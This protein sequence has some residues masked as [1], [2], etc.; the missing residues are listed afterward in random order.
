M[1]ELVLTQDSVSGSDDDGSHD[2]RFVQNVSPASCYGGGIEYWTIADCRLGHHSLISGCQADLCHWFRFRLPL[3]QNDNIDITEARLTLFWNPNIDLDIGN[4]ARTANVGISTGEE[5][6]IKIG[7]Y[8][9]DDAPY[10]TSAS[11]AKSKLAT[12]TDQIEWSDA[13]ID[14]FDAQYVDSVVSASFCE[15]DI[16]TL[17]EAATIYRPGW[18]SNNHILIFL[19]PVINPGIESRYVAFRTWSWLKWQI[20][21]GELNAVEMITA[22]TLYLEYTVNTP[23][24]DLGDKHVE[25]ELDI[26]QS[27]NVF[28]PQVPP[29]EHELTIEQTITTEMIYGREIEHELEIEQFLDYG[30]I[31]EETIIHDINLEQEIRVE[32]VRDTIMHVLD[33]E[34]TVDV[35]WILHKTIEHE[36]E[37]E[38]T[39][40][41]NIHQKTIWHTLDIVQTIET[42]G[43]GTYSRHV[44]HE[45]EIEQDIS[46]TGSYTLGIEHTLTIIQVFTGYLAGADQGVCARKDLLYSPTG[47]FPVEPTLVP[48]GALILEY[49]ITSP[50]YTVTLPSPLLSNREELNKTRIQRK[51]RA[52]DLKTFS[53]NSW[54]KSIIFRFKFQDLTDVQKL[55]LFTLVGA[56]LAQLVQLTDHEG[57]VWTGIISNPNGEYTQIFR[58]CGHTAE[59]DFQV[60]TYSS[61]F[62]E[63]SSGLLL[64]DSEPILL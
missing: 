54:P 1:S 62:Q 29:I 17:I 26:I 52:G 21:E 2:G 20:S 56:S 35:T 15:I 50:T 34:Q 12:I 58:E 37:I 18:S 40:E 22:P 42:E 43:I 8:A 36:L 32:L 13:I 3:A 25:H 19:S 39:I 31:M 41:T 53:D 55:D 63:D 57:R 7:V 33:I 45:L 28:N 46:F 14:S 24:S 9:S 23:G 47:D 49:P 6:T 61:A 59:F 44:E 60:I 51:T 30:S 64:E 16:S 10:P 27:I 5:L 4:P 38:Q 48:Q 11:D